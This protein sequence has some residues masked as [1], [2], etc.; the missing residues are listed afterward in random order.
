MD[1]FTLRAGIA[2]F[3]FVLTLIWNAP[4]VINVDNMWWPTKKKINYGLDIQGGLHLV[5]GV[6]VA[7]VV[8]ESTKRLIPALMSD[9]ATESFGVSTTVKVVNGEA[10]EIEITTT[11]AQKSKLVE[12][13]DNR[14]ANT[15][16][17]ISEGEG[18]LVYRYLEAYLMDYKSK[19]LAQAIETIRNRID[20]FGVA[21]PS[22]ASQG[23][24]RILIQ[25]PGM[26]DAERAKGLINTAAKLE[27]M[28][29][30]TPESLD[31]QSL[32]AEA[33]KAGGYD[34]QKMKYSEYI[35]RLN[36]DI[37]SKIPD[38]TVVYFEK[39]ANASSMDI[40]RIPFLLR[41]DT[42]LGGEFLDDARVGFD[43]FGKPNVNLRFNSAGAERFR[44][45]TGQNVG[46][47][48]AIV[49]DRI[50]KTAPRINGEIPSGSAEI[51]L[52]G[53][54]TEESMNEAKM[55][56]TSLRAGAL[57]ATLEQLEERRVGPTLGADSIKKAYFA[58]WVGAL[59]V[60]LFMILRYKAMGVVAVTSL[61]LNIL[62]MFGLLTSL[63]ATLTLPGIA[64]IA[65]TVGFAVDANVLIV[66]RM[67]EELRKG[68]SFLLA[69][70][71]GYSRAMSAILDANITT[72]ATA[73]VLLFFGTGPVK[74]FAVTLL[75]GIATTLFANV[76]V[77]HVLVDFLTG[78]LGIKK[79]SV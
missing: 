34:L 6:D 9:F 16:Q 5:M 74:G 58:S 11:E 8:T 35:A 25:L 54:N 10:G 77:S 4:N 47:P 57:P 39:S 56:S 78:K 31:L 73:I 61:A 23:S 55:I 19:V 72:A 79:L 14:Y 49:L 59:A 22:V 28:L 27:F 3:G 30:E 40:G 13:M 66:E 38:N 43:Q 12:F 45:L 51:T 32:V 1:S 33:E 20:E 75:V 71:E 67:R 70:K 63:G 64:G 44:K 65:L 52:G 7:G 50:V 42:G 69:V 41:T 24:D 37:K 46:R 2:V 68:S 29:V 17:M 76:F 36:A 48:M 18:K 60:V 62:T 26:A 53:R 21:E 15:M